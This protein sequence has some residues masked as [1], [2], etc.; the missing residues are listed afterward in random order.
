MIIIIIIIIISTMYDTLF[1]LSL[2]PTTSLIHVLISSVEFPL[3]PRTTARA[4][5]GA[6]D[7][8]PEALFPPSPQPTARINFRFCTSRSWLS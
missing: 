2:R 4:Y 3:E 6:R 1:P 7:L 8:S 5:R